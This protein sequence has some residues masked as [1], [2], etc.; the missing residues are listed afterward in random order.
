[1]ESKFHCTRSFVVRPD[2]FV[3][4]GNVL[5][6]TIRPGMKVRISFNPSFSMAS[7]IASIEHIN[8]EDP[9]TKIGLVIKCE[10]EDELELLEALNIGDEEM[11][12]VP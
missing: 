8:A 5:S 11:E 1:M 7:E 3:I 10:S 12:V 2:R 6:G 4:A 9:A